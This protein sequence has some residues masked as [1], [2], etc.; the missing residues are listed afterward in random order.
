MIQA[1]AASY[2]GL[3]LPRLLRA[4]ETRPGNS[5]SADACVVIFLN[6]GPNR[7]DMWD[8]KPDAPAEVRGEFKPIQTSVPG[9]MV[10]A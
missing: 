6:G 5:A 4:K 7:L 9:V 8:P 10:L 1:G 2:L 3:A